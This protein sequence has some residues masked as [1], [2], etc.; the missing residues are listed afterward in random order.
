MAAYEAEVIESFQGALRDANTATQR[1][2]ELASSD[3]LDQLWSS[4]VARGQSALSDA[5]NNCKKALFD[6]ELF[7][8]EEERYVVS[9]IASC[10]CCV[11][12]LVGRGVD[13]AK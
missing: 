4:Q 3:T 9:R 1:L 8:D 12:Q 7:V 10:L 6:F 13:V 2:F 11:S 5:I